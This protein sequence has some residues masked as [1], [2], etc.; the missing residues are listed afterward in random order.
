MRNCQQNRQ[1]VD[2]MR[3]CERMEICFR[4][5]QGEEDLQREGKSV[6]GYVLDLL[7]SLFNATSTAV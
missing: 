2:T 7:N 3:N 5:G 6:C 1:R 4:Q